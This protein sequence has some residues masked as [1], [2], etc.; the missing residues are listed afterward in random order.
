MYSYSNN[1]KTPTDKLR[2]ISNKLE[3]TITVQIPLKL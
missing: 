1:I 3:L 2:V